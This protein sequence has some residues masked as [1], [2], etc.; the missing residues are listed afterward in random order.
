MWSPSEPSH[1]DDRRFAVFVVL[2]QADQGLGNPVVGEELAGPPR[3]FRGDHVDLPQGPQAP[4]NVR[5]SRL[6][7]GVATTE[8]VPRW[9]SYNRMGSMTETYAPLRIP[10]SR[11]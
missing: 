11:V 7:I 2:V 8:R 1:S 3:V 4:R 6:P 10:V 9:R 5:S